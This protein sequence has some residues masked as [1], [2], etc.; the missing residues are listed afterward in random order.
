MKWRPIESVPLDG[1][2][3]LLRYV[4]KS[5]SSRT[6]VPIGTVVVTE[7]YYTPGW[8]GDWDKDKKFLYGAV[9]NDALGRL[10]CSMNAPSRKN[11]P[12]HWHPMLEEPE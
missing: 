5:S 4:K 3:V 11:I 7:A 6:L 9:W 1:T 10:I 8:Y 12:T 2:H